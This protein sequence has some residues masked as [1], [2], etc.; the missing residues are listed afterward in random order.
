MGRNDWNGE[1]FAIYI[2]HNDL[3]L[4]VRLSRTQN[5]GP[6]GDSFGR[7]TSVSNVH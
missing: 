1:T 3:K 7:I 4:Q 6:L 2:P 5:G